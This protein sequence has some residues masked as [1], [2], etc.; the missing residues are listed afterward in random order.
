MV[1]LAHLVLASPLFPTLPAHSTTTIHRVTGLEALF[2]SMSVLAYRLWLV[3]VGFVGPLQRKD[4]RMDQRM[5]C[6]HCLLDSH[7]TGP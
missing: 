4:Q 6:T 5:D 1:R 2:F 3:S 7:R